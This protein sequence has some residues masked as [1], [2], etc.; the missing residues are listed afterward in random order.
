MP[1]RPE[2]NG[3]H[4]TDK[5]VSVEVMGAVMRG[6]VNPDGINVINFMEKMWYNITG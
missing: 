5:A 1:R 4:E 3:Q 6:V 2:R